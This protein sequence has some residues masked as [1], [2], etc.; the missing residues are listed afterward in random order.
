V[1]SESACVRGEI[2]ADHV[3]INGTVRGP[4]HTSDLLEVAAQSAHRR[5]C[6]VQ[7]TGDASGRGD[8]GPVAP[9]NEVATEKPLLKLATKQQLTE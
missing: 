7:G 9:L 2:H 1:I 4:V 6:V 5:R 3:V 8:C